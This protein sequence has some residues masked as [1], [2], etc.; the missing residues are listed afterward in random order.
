MIADIPAL[1]QRSAWQALAAHYSQ[2]RNVH[3]RQLFADD[4]QRGERFAV[5][6]AGLYLDYSKHRV[7]D[8]TLKLLLQLA[9]ECDL[10]QRIDA[11]FRGE[12]INVTEHRAVLHVALRAPRGTSIVVDGENVVPQVHE[13]LDRMADFSNRV[14]GGAWT[15]HTGQRIRNVVNIGIGGSDLGPVMA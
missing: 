6:G 5:E 9:V 12:K 1:T 15:G 2:F 7:T 4:P 8:E 14:R 13:V 10:R 3:L 11:M